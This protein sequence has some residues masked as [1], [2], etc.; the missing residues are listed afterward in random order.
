MFVNLQH[1][2]ASSSAFT[3]TLTHTDANAD[4][5]SCTGTPAEAKQAL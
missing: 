5:H 4:T 2:A 1:A 3:Y